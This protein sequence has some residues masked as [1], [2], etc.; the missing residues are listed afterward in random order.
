MS[1]TTGGVA[2]ILHYT[3]IFMRL[4]LT[5]RDV[6]VVNYFIAD[7]F[8]L[9]VTN[10]LVH[11]CTDIETRLTHFKSCF[12]RSY[13]QIMATLLQKLR[14]RM[15]VNQSHVFAHRKLISLP[16][17]SMCI[18]LGVFACFWSSTLSLW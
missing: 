11:L 17:S 9:F 15:I 1:I 5:V 3:H 18:I 12:T 16:Q 6:L 4:V 14:F 2:L 10:S 13:R 8:E 7:L